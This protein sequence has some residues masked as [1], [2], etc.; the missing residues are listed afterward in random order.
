MIVVGVDVAC[1]KEH[2]AAG[3]AGFDGVQG[4]FGF[5]F[6][7]AGSGAVLGV[8][9]VGIAAGLGGFL[10]LDFVDEVLEVEGVGRGGWSEPPATEADMVSGL[11]VQVVPCDCTASVGVCSA[12]M[13]LLALTASFWAWRSAAR[14]CA[15]FG[16]FR[17]FLSENTNGP[18]RVKTRA[19]RFKVS[20]S[21]GRNEL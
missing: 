15:R 16:M 4:R 6:V 10:F 8:G 17:D 2:G 13:V 3:E 1:G 20:R 21:M 9:A 5:A 11:L 7:G 19:S 18:R 14:R 12:N